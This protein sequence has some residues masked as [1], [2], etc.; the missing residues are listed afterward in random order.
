MKTDRSLL[1]SVM[2][3]RRGDHH[4]ELVR[5]ARRG[6]LPDHVKRE[7][8]GHPSN[9][10]MTIEVLLNYVT[11]EM[12]GEDLAMSGTDLSETMTGEEHGM[13]VHVTQGTGG[14]EPETNPRPGTTTGE[15][16]VTTDRLHVTHVTLE[17]LPDLA[18][19][20]RERVLIAGEL[21]VLKDATIVMIETSEEQGEEMRR[22]VVGHLVEMI[23]GL[24]MNVLVT[25]MSV[26]GTER[27]GPGWTGMTDLEW[28]EMID[29]GWT[30]MTD[31]G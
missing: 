8:T 17:D 7:M 16:S 9:H 19:R 10:V 5:T 28:T 23:A 24:E 21:L 6:V 12:R 4:L 14:E 3:A 22:D 11:P 30:E 2:R 25:E 13:T 1:R 31:P 20:G 27:N 15:G 29:P 18:K 26:P